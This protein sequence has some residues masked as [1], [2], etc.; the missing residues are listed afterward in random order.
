MVRKIQ[1]FGEQSTDVMEIHIGDIIDVVVD[2]EGFLFSE[3]D[4]FSQKI[5]YF[6]NEV[7]QGWVVAT[8]KNLSEGNLSHESNFSLQKTYFHQLHSVLELKSASLQTLSFSIS[9]VFES[10]NFISAQ[11]PICYFW[12]WDPLRKAAALQLSKDQ[13]T[14]SRK[15]NPKGMN[16]AVMATDALT[17]SRSHFRLHVEKVGKCKKWVLN[18]QF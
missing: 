10:S 9:V 18:I 11:K 14:V 12:R 6:N 7:L 15:E 1:M 4:Q 17:K 8:Q 16:P 2:F 5:L 13:F 3:T